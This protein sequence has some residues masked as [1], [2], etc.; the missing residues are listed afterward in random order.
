MIFEFKI[1]RVRKQNTI[2][3]KTKYRCPV[4][5]TNFGWFCN[6]YFS[7]ILEKISVEVDPQNCLLDPE[8]DRSLARTKS[9]V[10]FQTNF[11]IKDIS[12]VREGWGVNPSNLMKTNRTI[13]GKYI[14]KNRNSPPPKKKLFWIWPSS[15]KNG[16]VSYLPLT[17]ST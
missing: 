4:I 10:R 9:F 16:T 14:R 6:W 11:L 15:L 1:S 3:S 17:G 8:E 7:K 13:I 5:E 12:G 2:I